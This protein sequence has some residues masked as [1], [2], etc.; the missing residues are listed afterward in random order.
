MREFVELLQ[1]LDL[2]HDFIELRHASIFNNGTA[3]HERTVAY[4]Y[5]MQRVSAIV[6]DDY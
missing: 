3:A 2:A 6:L 1:V 5:T 4:L